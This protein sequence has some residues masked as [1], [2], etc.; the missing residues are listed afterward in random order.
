MVGNRAENPI[1]RFLTGVGHEKIFAGAAFRPRG[2]I[3]HGLLVPQG[4]QRPVAQVRDELTFEVEEM[5]SQ[6]LDF[7]P[8]RVFWKDRNL[9][10][11][12]CNLAFAETAGVAPADIVGKDDFELPWKEQ[13]DLYRAH[14]LIVLEEGIA[15]EGYTEPVMIDGVLVTVRTTKFPLVDRK[16]NI[17]GVVGFFEPLQ[18]AGA[19]RG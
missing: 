17:A 15:L 8:A 5:F 7:L 1:V 13:A 6:L 2:A 19:G 11:V 18:D 3:R 10:Y 4:S 14:D 16:G 9:R 12:G